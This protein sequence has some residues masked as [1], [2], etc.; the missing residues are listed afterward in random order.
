MSVTVDQSGRIV[1]DRD[2]AELGGLGWAWPWE[3]AP[4]NHSWGAAIWE[5]SHA[6]QVRQEEIALGVDSPRTIAQIRSDAWNDM[7]AA[8]RELVGQVGATAGAAVDAVGSAVDAIT[9]GVKGA[10]GLVPWLVGGMIVYSVIQAL[11]KLP[12][13]RG[14]K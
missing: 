9:E 5:Y 4:D 10:A 3:G 6:G 12:A 8:D 7:N 13:R 2:R 14:G 1:R 11:G